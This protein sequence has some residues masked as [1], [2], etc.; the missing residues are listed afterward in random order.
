V[1]N[2]GA[3]ASDVQKLIELIHSRVAERLGVDLQTEIEIW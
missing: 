1:A 2:A 3:T